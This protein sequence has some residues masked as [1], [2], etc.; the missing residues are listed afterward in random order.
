MPVNVFQIGYHLV[1]ALDKALVDKVGDFSFQLV[2]FPLFLFFAVLVADI[3]F[4][5]V[6]HNPVQR[7]AYFLHGLGHEVFPND[8]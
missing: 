1:V 3:P 7:F 4:M 2:Q 5:L 8:L 6:E